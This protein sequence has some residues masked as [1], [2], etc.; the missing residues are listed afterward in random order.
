[1]P[2]HFLELNLLGLLSF[3]FLSCE[4]SCWRNIFWFLEL[5]FAGLSLPNNFIITDDSH[6]CRHIAI[7]QAWWVLRIVGFRLLQFIYTLYILSSETWWSTGHI[8]KSLTS[9][10]GRETSKIH[11][12]GMLCLVF[13]ILDEAVR[14][15]NLWLWNLHWCLELIFWVRLIALLPV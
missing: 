14:I 8:T 5:N 10:H 12:Y 2:H 15:R 7:I 4:I 9:F 1:M 11:L 6:L 3:L 13:T